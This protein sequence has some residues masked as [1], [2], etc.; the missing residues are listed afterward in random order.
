MTLGRRLD[1]ED[2]AS[3]VEFALIVPL[4]V[5][6]VFGIIE[7]GV[8]YLQVQS[9]RTGVREGGRA[10]AVGA[11]KTTAQQKTAAGSAGTITDPKDVGVSKVCNAQN[12]GDDV[13]V[14]YDTQNM[15]GG[16][17]VVQIPFVTD[18]VLTPVITAN[19][20]CEV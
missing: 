14:T 9:I 13:T 1:R 15:P 6:L 4:L 2:G 11:P 19:F 5:I 20:R 12:I 3:A 10:A 7:F 8:A 17:I 16:G 18:V